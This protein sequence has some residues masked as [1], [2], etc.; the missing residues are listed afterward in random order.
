MSAQ[1]GKYS[2]F[3]TYFRQLEFQQ[4]DN[5]LHQ[6]LLLF[7]DTADNNSIVNV[8]YFMYII[9][10]DKYSTTEG[11]FAIRNEREIGLKCTLE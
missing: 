8:N 3:P 6:L 10:N 9:R 5:Y 11:H 2:N 4:S 7:W 1:S